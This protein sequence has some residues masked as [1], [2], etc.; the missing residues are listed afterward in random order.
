M[1]RRKKQERRIRKKRKSAMRAT[2]LMRRLR[3]ISEEDFEEIMEFWRN[4]PDEAVLRAVN[5][6]VQDAGYEPEGG[7]RKALRRARGK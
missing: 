6:G 2:R 4:A 7:L 5:R 3:Q 1:S